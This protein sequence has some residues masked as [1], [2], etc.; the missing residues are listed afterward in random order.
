MYLIYLHL[1]VNLLWFWY[2][3]VCFAS[4]SLNIL[5]NYIWKFNLAVLTWVEHN[6]ITNQVNGSLAILPTHIKSGILNLWGHARLRYRTTSDSLAW[7]SIENGLLSLS[8]FLSMVNSKLFNPS[9]TKLQG[10]SLFKFNL[11]QISLQMWQCMSTLTGSD[12]DSD[13]H[14]IRES[15]RW[16]W[17]ISSPTSC[18]EQS[19]LQWQSTLMCNRKAAIQ[20]LSSFSATSQSCTLINREVPPCPAEGIF[21]PPLLVPPLWHLWLHSYFHKHKGV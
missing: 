1:S 20:W 2:G 10:K 4:L 15:D 13:D 19:Q 6:S 11:N 17:E 3:W 21:Q 14:S 18:S 5:Q 7:L 12:C 8:V 9:W 16:P